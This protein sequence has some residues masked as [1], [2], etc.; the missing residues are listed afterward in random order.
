MINRDYIQFNT[1]LFSKIQVDAIKIEAGE[2]DRFLSSFE[3]AMA[4]FK[5]SS[6][7]SLPKQD[8]E[9]EIPKKSARGEVKK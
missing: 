4:L 5:S 9:E 6:K 8:T 2:E 3:T 1:P 7:Q